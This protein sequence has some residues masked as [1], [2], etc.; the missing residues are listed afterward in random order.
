M[1]ALPALELRAGAQLPFKRAQ[2]GLQLCLDDLEEVDQLHHRISASS[3]V[4]RGE[5]HD[6]AVVVFLTLEGA[7][8]LHAHDPGRIVPHQGAGAT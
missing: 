2:E 6:S 3:R 5:I 4:L 1:S 8:H 7:P